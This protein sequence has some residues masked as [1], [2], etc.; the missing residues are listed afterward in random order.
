MNTDEHAAPQTPLGG[1]LRELRR[2]IVASGA[3]LLDW[4][5]LDEEVQGRLNAV[6][7]KLLKVC[8][9]IARIREAADSK[10]PLMACQGQAMDGYSEL[11]HYRQAALDAANVLQAIESGEMG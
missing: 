4:D 9:T 2:R 3:P 7:L 1:R 11:A 5:E 6:S 8:E 10:K